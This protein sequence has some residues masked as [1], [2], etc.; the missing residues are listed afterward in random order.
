METQNTDV[1]VD[2]FETTP[3]K[4]LQLGSATVEKLSDNEVGWTA[5]GRRRGSVEVAA[6]IRAELRG[7]ELPVS[8]EDALKRWIRD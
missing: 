2:P 7:S 8:W 3:E 4:A 6:A 1:T 5:A